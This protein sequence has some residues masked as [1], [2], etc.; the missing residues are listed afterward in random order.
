MFSNSTKVLP[1]IV[2]PGSGP[3]LCGRDWLAQLQLDW[4]TILDTTNHSRT[5]TNVHKEVF[6]KNL[7][8]IEGF[9]GPPGKIK[10]RQVPQAMKEKIEVELRKL[11]EQSI[12]VP[13]K[14]SSWAA[15][16]VSILKPDGILRLCSDYKVTVNE[17][18][19]LESYPLPRIEE[20]F[21]SL[22][23]GK[24]FTEALAVLFG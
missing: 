7:E 13:V 5:S 4:K 14:Y 19:K 10:S 1:V 15:P 22:V 16:V 18:A 17:V 9:N 3:N 11:E 20:L 23:G 2:V 12:I 6:D 21:S 8:K 24:L